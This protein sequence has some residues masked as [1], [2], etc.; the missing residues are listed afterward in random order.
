M[1]RQP[2]TVLEKRAAADCE[3]IERNGEA[4]IV[5]EW[6]KSRTWGFCPRIDNMYGLERG[7]AAYAS[8]CGYDKLSAVL[9]EYLVWLVPDVAHSSGAG[10]SSVK[11]RLA[12]AGWTLTAVA[13]TKT[14][15]V[16]T[17]ERKETD[18]E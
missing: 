13:S 4:T 14:S 9:C 11:D 17:L 15:D 12:A 10:V 1:N 6:S 2:N 3:R 7:K 16:F 18:N 5:V 8:G